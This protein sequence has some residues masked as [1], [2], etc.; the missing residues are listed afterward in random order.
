[1]RSHPLEDDWDEDIAI[2]GKQLPAKLEEEEA[3]KEAERLV[4]MLEDF[5]E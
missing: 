5:R 2:G 4:Q 3:K 1:M